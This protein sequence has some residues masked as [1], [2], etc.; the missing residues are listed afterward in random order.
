MRVLQPARL[1]QGVALLGTGSHLPARI[2]DNETILDAGGPFESAAEIERVTG[3]RTRRWAAPEVA[4]S[5]LATAAGQAALQ[6]AGLPP[7]A[8]ARLILGT[9]TPDH[10]TPSTACAVQAKLGLGL[11]PAFDLS[12]ACSGFV[13]ALDL[14][15]RSVLTGEGPVLA[16][17]A[18]LR[19]R[20]LNPRDRGTCALFGDGAGAAILG[21]GPVGEGLLAIGLAADGRGVGEV[22]VPAGGSREPA[23]AESVAQGRHF[24]HMHDGARV[25]MSAVA[26]M[27]E[28]GA[29]VL[30]AEGLSWGDL[31]LLIPHQANGHILK[32]LAWK[33]ELPAEKVVSTLPELGNTAGSSAAIALDR[34]WRGPQLPP[35]GLALLVVA[36]AGHTVGAALLRRPARA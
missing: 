1:G 13:Y 7:E 8:I 34:A 32:R 11:V 24:V 10:P 5:E 25:Y 28:A 19:S 36:G 3:I 29:A 22:Q 31:D 9:V 15:A 18:D 26:G 2:V 20:F 27:L 35:G 23:S 33:A 21:P 12:A 14:A 4:T 30:E 16:I 17:G 6:A